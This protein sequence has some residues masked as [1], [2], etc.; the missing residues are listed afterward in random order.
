MRKFVVGVAAFV[1][2]T[3]TAYIGLFQRAAVMSLFAQTKLAAQGYTAA[4]TPDEALDGFRKALKERNYEAAEL[5]LGGDFTS[6]FHRARRTARKSASPSTTCPASWKPP[7]R[8]RT[9]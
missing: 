4:K 9:R 2:V 1:V 8:S 5:Y 3:L 7:A 6:E